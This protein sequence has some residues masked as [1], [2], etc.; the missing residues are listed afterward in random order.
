ML[1]VIISEHNT[2]TVR[3]VKCKDICWEKVQMCRHKPQDSQHPRPSLPPS[4]RSST[5][6]HAVIRRSLNYNASD[7]L[8]YVS[9][10]AFTAEVTIS[11]IDKHYTFELIFG[12]IPFVKCC[13]SNIINLNIFQAAT[14]TLEW[15]GEER[16]D[17]V[18]TCHCT[19]LLRCSLI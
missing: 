16:A 11:S 4:H 1:V 9:P 10:T 19:N 15:R 8:S 5:L 13:H 3:T 6:Q 18:K 2:D 14:N 12:Q 7:V 17:Q